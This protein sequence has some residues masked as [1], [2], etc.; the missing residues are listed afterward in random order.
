MNAEMVQSYLRDLIANL[1][2]SPRPDWDSDGDLPVTY[3]GSQ[4]YARVIRAGEELIVQTFSVVS[5]VDYTPELG[6][7]LNELNRI[8]V[9]VRGFHTGGQILLEN[10]LFAHDLNGY[11]LSRALTFLAV[12]TTDFGPQ[13]VEKFG[14]KPRFDPTIIQQQIPVDEDPPGLYL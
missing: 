6:E 12:T 9:F 4:C 3:R 14:G 7:F 8:L 11:T 10:D 1:T 2:D 13:M 5:E